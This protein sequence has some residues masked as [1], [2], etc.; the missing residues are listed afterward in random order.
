MVLQ[1]PLPSLHGGSSGWSWEL[2]GQEDRVERELGMW[3][4]PPSSAFSFL[5]FTSACLLLKRWGQAREGYLCHL[6]GKEVW[7]YFNF[8][9]LCY[10]SAALMSVFTCF[11][12][13]SWVVTTWAHRFQQREEKTIPLKRTWV[14]EKATLNNQQVLNLGLLLF[15]RGLKIPWAIF[16]FCTFLPSYLPHFPS[17]PM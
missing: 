4:G 17:S 11:A 10:L 6:K 7:F 2:E 5:P 3:G 8:S 16:C 15:V 14:K 9:F 13:W 12:H 1:V